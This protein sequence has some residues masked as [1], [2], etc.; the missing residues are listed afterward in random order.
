MGWQRAEAFPFA[1]TVRLAAL[2]S[3]A[4]SERGLV[5][6]VDVS[7][8]PKVDPVDCRMCQPILPSSLWPPRQKLEEC[9]NGHTT[10]SKRRLGSISLKGDPGQ[11]YIDT[12]R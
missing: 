9:V 6:A 11:D 4:V 3:Q 5:W 10:N 1:S 8:G 2:R 7:G 12:P